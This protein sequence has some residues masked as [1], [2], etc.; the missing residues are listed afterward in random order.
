MF[1]FDLLSFYGNFLCKFWFIC[2]RHQNSP[3]VRKLVWCIAYIMKEDSCLF[4]SKMIKSDEL[5]SHSFYVW[6]LVITIWTR[7][8][9]LCQNS[10]FWNRHHPF[11]VGT[12]YLA[13]IFPF[14][15]KHLLMTNCWAF[16][17]GTILMAY[18]LPSVWANYK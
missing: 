18:F 12:I 7:N 9:N 4:L 16:R 5:L 13:Y 15:I 14:G 6:T 2:F 10:A 17:D 3:W 1:C 8:I 11:W